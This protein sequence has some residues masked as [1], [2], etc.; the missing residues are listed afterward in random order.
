MVSIT[1]YKKVIE[2]C[3]KYIIINKQK[4][5]E[6]EVT[7]II[8]LLKRLLLG[9][10]GKNRKKAKNLGVGEKRELTFKE[11]GQE[12][13]QVLRMLGN[14]CLVVTREYIGS[15]RLEAFCFDAQKR[16]CTIRG[17]LRNRVWINTVSFPAFPP[18]LSDHNMCDEI[19]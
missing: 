3:I 14:S 4:C 9:K 1:I 13:A 12:Y 18:S 6:E 2:N 8:C 17:K 11:E 5:Q 7:I 10:G 16:M 19:G 15:G